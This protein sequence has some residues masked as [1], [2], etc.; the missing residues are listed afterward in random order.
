M[1]NILQENG[2]RLEQLTI[3]IDAILAL[4]ECEHRGLTAAEKSRLAKLEK[5]ADELEAEC[6]AIREQDEIRGR[7]LA[8]KNYLETPPERSTLLEP[9]KMHF[10]RP[11]VFGP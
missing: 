9:T 3:E 2:E 11:V 4:P 1:H 8:R 7:Q 10:D 5:Q 6:K